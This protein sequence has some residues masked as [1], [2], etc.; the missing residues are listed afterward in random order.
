MLLPNVHNAN[1]T[2]YKRRILPIELSRPLLHSKD[3][4]FE[5]HC[6]QVFFWHGSV[7]NL[8]V[9]ITSV[10]FEHHGKNNFSPNQWIIRVKSTLRL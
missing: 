5:P 10:A 2:V 3:C 9:Q 6:R 7:A 1:N 8:S 4:R